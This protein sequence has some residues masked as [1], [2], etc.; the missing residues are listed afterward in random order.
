MRISEAL[1]MAKSSSK[2]FEDAAYKMK[3][4][5][6]YELTDDLRFANSPEVFRLACG[7]LKHR[8]QVWHDQVKKWEGGAKAEDLKKVPVSFVMHRMEI[9][10]GTGF[11]VFNHKSREFK[12]DILPSDFFKECLK[13]VDSWGK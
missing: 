8:L 9:Y 10:N 13:T 3:L 4:N 5:D 11:E 12:P 7:I 1:S 6:F 2:D